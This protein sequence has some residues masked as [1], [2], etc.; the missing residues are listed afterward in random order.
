MT[1]T[2][3]AAKSDP[4]MLKLLVFDEEDLAVISANLQDAIVR[5]SDMAFLQ[6]QQRFAFTAARFDWIAA[7]EGRCERLQ[8]G[9][10]FERVTSVRT[11]GFRPA[12]T[13]SAPV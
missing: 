8:T 12:L 11:S 9:L 13:P 2:S 3:T 4:G 7:D 5:A 1:A 6:K 10:H